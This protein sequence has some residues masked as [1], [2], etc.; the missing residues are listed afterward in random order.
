M[1]ALVP[2][3]EIVTKLLRFGVEG[4]SVFVECGCGWGLFHGVCGVGR[5]GQGYCEDW[6]V[7]EVIAWVVLESPCRVFSKSCYIVAD[8]TE[9]GVTPPTTKLHDGRFVNIVGVQKHCEG[10]SNGVSSDVLD[11]DP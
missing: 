6:V 4:G 9:N 2:F 8:V 11:V 10:T 7:R 5:L 3:T 1:F